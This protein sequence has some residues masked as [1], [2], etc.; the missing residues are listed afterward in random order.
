MRAHLIDVGQGAAT[1]FEFSCGA[2]LVDTG[3][4]ANGY[5]DSSNAL[6]AYLADFFDRR[7]DLNRTIDLLVITHPHRD[8]ALNARLVAESFTVRNVVT[9]GRCWR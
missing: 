1:L 8:H 2:V 3:G 6:V 7:R 9:D 5:F 4:E